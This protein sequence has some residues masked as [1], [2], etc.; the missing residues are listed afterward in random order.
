MTD[1]DSKERFSNRVENYTKFRP[2]Y[3]AEAI[4][5]MIS[6]TGINESS[7]IAD[8]GSGTGKFTRLLLERGF[9]VLA[10]EPNANMRE[11]AEAEL[12]RFAGF[13]S[14]LASA[15]ST[16][17]DAHSVDLITVAQSFHWFDQEICKA[18]FRRILKS[19]GGHAAL[20]YNRRETTPGL[21]GDYQEIIKKWYDDYSAGSAQE[22]ITPAVY[23]AFFDGNYEIHN[24]F[25]RESHDFEALL[26]RSLSN[27]HAPTEGQPNY[28]PLRAAL[29][30][31]F[32]RYNENGLIYF[33]Y[34]TEVVIG[35][36]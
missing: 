36:W 1:I 26:G 3:P 24:F 14:V 27:S 21:M 2:S 19:E 22:H 23:D 15:E 18:E 17:L 28:E 9:S 13:R 10:L 30:E 32:E 29:R 6:Q 12:S 34:K 8:I 16:T 5:C 4:D 11:A 35:R 25:W 7:V 31:L 20:I 33:S